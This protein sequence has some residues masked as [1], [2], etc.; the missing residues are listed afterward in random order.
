MFK[1]KNLKSFVK[2]NKIDEHDV[3]H[4]KNNKIGITYTWIKK[5]LPK[6]TLNLPP[7]NDIKQQELVEVK[8]TL[9]KYKCKSFN[10]VLLNLDSSSVQYY[11]V[12]KERTPFF[13]KKGLIKIMVLFNQLDDKIYDW[14]TELHD[15]ELKPHCENL[16]NVKEMVNLAH[17]PLIKNVGGNMTL[18]P[19]GLFDISLDDVVIDFKHVNDYKK[20]LDIVKW[21]CPLFSQIQKKCKEEINSVEKSFEERLKE[22]KQEKTIEVLKKE[23]DK[24]K[25]L[26]DQALSLTQS[27]IP[28]PK[29][30]ESPAESKTP[31]FLKP[32]KI[33]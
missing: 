26:K 15:G 21:K 4:L 11:F 27:F 19:N 1:N 12:D 9:E 13:T 18:H 30:S 6:F 23:L 29:V 33:K 17:P 25:S 8:P 3:V 28:L 20:D 31:V 16:P 7:L 2:N 5:N 32:S 14:I 22:L 10:P 24:E